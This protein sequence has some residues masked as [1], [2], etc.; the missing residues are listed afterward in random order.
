MR[1]V[2]SPLVRA[3]AGI[4]LFTQLGQNW[5]PAS[6]GMSGGGDLP[7]PRKVDIAKFKQSNSPRM[8]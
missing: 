7:G 8:N 5:F 1:M 4:Q 6:A 3:E 2:T